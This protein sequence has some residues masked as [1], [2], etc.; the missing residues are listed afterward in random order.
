MYT[1]SPLFLSTPFN[2][3]GIFTVFETYWRLV[4]LFV[5]LIVMLLSPRK[6][7][8]ERV[9]IPARASLK[10]LPAKEGIQGDD[11]YEMYEVIMNVA[12]GKP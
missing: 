11:V 1:F 2:L 3:G 5:G 7:D 4:L 12:Y 8:D 10:I 9:R 6:S